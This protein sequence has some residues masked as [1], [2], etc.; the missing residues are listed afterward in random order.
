MASVAELLWEEV[1]K[2]HF[3]EKI[4]QELALSP[5][6]AGKCL[7]FLV[8]LHDIGKATPV[9]QGQWEEARK[10]LEESG[11]SCPLP[12]LK[13]HHSNLTTCLLMELLRELLSSF[14]MATIRQIAFILGDI[15][16]FFLAKS[17]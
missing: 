6:W 2:P 10:R 14:P 9:F 13:V 7:A 17:T 11:F 15:T 4:S 12:S 5:E 1:L 8:G 3:K 16:A